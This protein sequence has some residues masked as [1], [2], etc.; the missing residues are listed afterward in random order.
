MTESR[1]RYYGVGMGTVANDQPESSADSGV[2]PAPA[3]GMRVREVLGAST[4]TGARV[5]AGAAGLDGWY[6]G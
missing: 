3:L 5:L 6:G 1:G 4:L 2:P